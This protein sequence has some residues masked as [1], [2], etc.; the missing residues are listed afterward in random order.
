MLLSLMMTVRYN[1][2]IIIFIII[3]LYGIYTNA[4]TH[5]HT[6]SHRLLLL[7]LLHSEPQIRGNNMTIIENRSPVRVCVDLRGA[8]QSTSQDLTITFT[9]QLKPSATNPATR[10]NMKL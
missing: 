5:T 1:Y 4:C 6:F 10:K 3:Q 7:L 8:T 2:M 9:P